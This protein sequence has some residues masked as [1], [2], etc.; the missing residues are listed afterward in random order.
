MPLARRRL[1][2]QHPDDVVAQQQAVQLL[3]HAAGRLAPQHRTLALMG[4]Q[5]INR[6]FLLPPFVVEHDQGLGRVE[7]LVQQRRQQPVR[8]ARA[9]AAGIIEGVL[10]DPHQ[11]AVAVLLAGRRAA[12]ELGQVGAVVQ[13]P[14][15]LEDQVRLDPGQQM[16]PR[17][18]TS[19]TVW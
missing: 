15:R 5:F 3:H 18:R 2:H 8:L 11:D 1:L 19:A 10:D 13:H 6:E 14:D 17:W 16:R 4:L 9:G 12:V 7:L